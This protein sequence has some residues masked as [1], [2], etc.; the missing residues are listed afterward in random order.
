[1]EYDPG[2]NGQFE[3]DVWPSVLP[4]DPLVIGLI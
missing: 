1:M 3:M 4:P 2:F